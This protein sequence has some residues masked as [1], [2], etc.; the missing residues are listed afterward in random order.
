MLING[1]EVRDRLWIVSK[2]T[3]RASDRLSDSRGL[4]R[5]DITI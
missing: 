2:H 4:G 5:L 3:A 1:V